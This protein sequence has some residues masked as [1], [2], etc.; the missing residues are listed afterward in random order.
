VCCGGSASL[1]GV[2]TVFG[3]ANSIC[4]LSFFCLGGAVWLVEL[5]VFFCA[6]TQ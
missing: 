4:A 1:Y 6:A 5:V 3:G 2:L